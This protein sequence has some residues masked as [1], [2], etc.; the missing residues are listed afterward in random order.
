MK[1]REV[2]LIFKTH[3]DVGFTDLAEN[4]MHKYLDAYIPEAIKVGYELKDSSTPFVWTVGSFLIWEALKRDSDGSVDRAIRDGIL[5]WHALPFTTHTE[6]MNE[7]LFRLGL[8][9]SQ[10]LDARYGRK[11]TGAKMTDVPGHTIGMVPLMQQSGITLLH[12]GVNTA[13]PVPPVPPAFRWKCGESEITVLYQGDYGSAM[14]FDDFV[15][16]FAHTND[17]LGPQTSEQVVK[18]YSDVQKLY[19]DCTLRAATLDDA[20]RRVAG[21]RDLPVFEKE[22]GDTWIHGAGTDPQKISRYRRLLRYLSENGAPECDLSDSLLMVPEHTWGMDQ[23]TF[24]RNETAFTAGELEACADW[25]RDIERSWQE[26]RDYVAAA[27]KLLGL[28]SEYPISQPRL[29]D[30]EIAD[31]AEEPPF[32]ISWEIFD[33]SDYDRY[34]RDYVRL[35][36]DTADWA[37]WDFT[38]VGLPEYKGGIYTAK[39]AAAYRRNDATLWRMEFDADAASAYG[40]PYFFVQTAGDRIEIKWFGKKISRLPQACWLKFRGLKEKWQL[41]KLGQWID[42]DDVAGSPLISA[43]DRGVRNSDVEIRPLDSALV[44]PYGRRLL[45]YGCTGIQQD[46]YFN[47]YNNIWNTNFPIWYGDDAMFRFE[48]EKRP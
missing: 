11:T 9:L 46:M 20:A 14:E 21:L 25:R 34:L 18:A 30:Y 1:K 32:E 24:F 7:E 17:N 45:Q 43:V 22:I 27:E 41:H 28:P 42:A 2:L 8:S 31:I 3:L 36:S 38:R 4:I 19:P 29:S 37:V 10:K 47:L 5:C 35:N 33:R 15:I 12:I 44:A 39:A 16:Y 23:K 26:Q 40:L 48:I 6:L 13:T